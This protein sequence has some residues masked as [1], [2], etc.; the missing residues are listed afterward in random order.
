MGRP[1]QLLPWNGRTLL[2][3][4]CEVAL[5]T[6]C[7]P[8]IVVLGC[9]A[10]A[11]ALE[12]KGLD[13]IPVI[14]AQWQK[15]MGTS[16]ATGVAALEKKAPDAKGVLLMLVDQ[17]TVTSS[18]LQSLATRWSPPE[19][20]IVAMKYPE[21]GG[22]PALFDRAHFA[23]LRALDADRGARG[24][25]AREKSRVALLDPRADL[26]DLDTPQ[27]YQASVTS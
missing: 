26:I 13:V 2:R 19:V 15:G 4:A 7:R 22:V 5:E 8:V 16:V 6:S 12:L 9:E 14:N 27:A 17:P 25:I 20:S 24:I 10:D 21:G 1:K 23:D 18:L 11:C 3:H